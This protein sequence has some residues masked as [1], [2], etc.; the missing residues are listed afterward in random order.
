MKPLA[1]LDRPINAPAEEKRFAFG[2]NWQRFLASLREERIAEAETSLRI[3]L[4]FDDLKGKSFL[5]IGCGSGLFSLAAMRLG[6]RRAH[7]FDYDPNSVACAAELKRRYFPEMPH[8]EIEQGSVLDVEYLARL[9]T[10]DIVYSWGVLH[11]T[12][13]M[14]SA[15]QN[16]MIPVAGH[17]VLFIALYND[18]GLRS[19]LWTRIKKLYNHDPVSRLALTLFFGTFY[20]VWRFVKDLARLRDPRERYRDYKKSRGMSYFTDLLD[21]IGGYPFEVAKREDVVEFFEKNGFA[22]LKLNSAGDGRG[23]NEFL[24]ARNG[25]IHR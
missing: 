14:S 9:G 11:H 8:W 15:L 18:Q 4:G 20:A 17:G 12:G 23:N 5:D 24:F 7:S 3:M 16:V 1:I 21:W 22:L 13:N 25:P 6:A 2:S 19:R 10:F